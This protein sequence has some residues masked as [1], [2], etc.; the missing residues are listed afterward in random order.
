MR[1]FI[2]A[3]PLSHHIP[4]RLCFSIA[5][6]SIYG[7]HLIDAHYILYSFATM[8]DL[9]ILESLYYGGDA[10]HVQCASCLSEASQHLSTS[11]AAKIA[12][13]TT[14]PKLWDI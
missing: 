11:L 4:L 12:T 8:H 7:D 1:V 2:L 10:A 14:W 13:H 9:I 6:E 3:E 5:L